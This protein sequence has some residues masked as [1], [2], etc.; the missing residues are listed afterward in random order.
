M[1]QALSIKF[2]KFLITFFAKLLLLELLILVHHGNKHLDTGF[3]L[4][5]SLLH[6]L[7][8]ACRIHAL[9]DKISLL[10]SR[11]FD[12][13]ALLHKD[14]NDTLKA[15][16]EASGRSILTGKLADHLVVSSAACNGTAKAF[17][18]NLEDGSG[19]VAHSTD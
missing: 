13:A 9:L 5:H 8:V 11:I 16:R 3:A 12:F 17:H 10:R 15:D 6:D 1:F 4:A 7:S 2:F 19:V 14:G 18:G